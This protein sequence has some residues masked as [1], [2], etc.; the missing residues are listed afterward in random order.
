[1]QKALP[2]KPVPTLSAPANPDTFAQ[3]AQ[4]AK[5]GGNAAKTA[6]EQL[7]KELGHSVISPEN[8]KT[9][10]MAGSMELLIMQAKYR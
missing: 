7:E 1:M 9:L 6:R 4:V 2:A 3:H 5:R 8:A 10:G